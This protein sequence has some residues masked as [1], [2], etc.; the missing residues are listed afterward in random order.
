MM[1]A[2]QKLGLVKIEP[3]KPPQP[4]EQKAQSRVPHNG[5]QK[6]RSG[7][8]R[9]RAAPARPGALSRHMGK[10]LYIQS[11]EDAASVAGGYER[12]AAVLGVGTD[13]V[14]RWRTGSAIP[15]CAV[16][17]RVIE[18]VLNDAAKPRQAEDKVT[19]KVTA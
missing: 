13:E 11:V 7:C 18:L 16:L 5:L 15:E 19:A 6:R 17:L 9:L 3:G 8:G 4:V 10:A 14:E 1:G 2:L 12:L